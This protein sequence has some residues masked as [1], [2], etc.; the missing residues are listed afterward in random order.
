MAERPLRLP[1]LVG[2][3][4]G[5]TACAVSLLPWNAPPWWGFALTALAVLLSESRVVNLPFGGQRWSFAW[6]EVPVAAALLVKPGSWI[7]VS[8][9]VGVM[10]AQA[11]RRQPPVKQ[12]FNTVQLAAAASVAIAVALPIG[13]ELGVTAGMAT[14]WT[15]NTA[16]VAAAIW[17]T[18]DRKFLSVCVDGAPLMALHS[19]TNVSLAILGVWIATL[20]PTGLLALLAPAGLLAWALIDQI[21]RTGETQLLAELVRAHED[22]VSDTTDEVVGALLEVGSR[23]LP[24]VAV[25]L[26]VF[27]ADGPHLYRRQSRGGVACHRMRVGDFSESWALAAT[28]DD[29]VTRTRDDESEALLRVGRAGSPLGLIRMI[30][31]A[32]GATLN[33]QSMQVLR[34]L[35]RHAEASLSV[36]RALLSRDDALERASAATETV[37]ALSDISA[38]TAPALRVLRDSAGRLAAL[39]ANAPA[40]E[41]EVTRLVEELYAV[42]RAVASLCGAIT[43]AAVPGVEDTDGDGV[44]LS[45]DRAEAWTRTG[46]LESR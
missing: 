9:A 34:M 22:R 43:L 36:D 27:T 2:V 40:D 33:R 46:L 25:E 10:S 44:V 42:E 21:Q 7:A 35:S 16:L 38:D 23:L 12:V 45:V 5:G 3:V 39:A 20:N 1:L 26:V 6:A 24:N 31:T 17:I 8:V 41:V 29:P 18:T 32:P 19:A 4:A 28:S 14:F 13:G 30:T 37:R 15:A 11:M